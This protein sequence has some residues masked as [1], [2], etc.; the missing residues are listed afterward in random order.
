MNRIRYWWWR[1]QGL[2][3]SLQ[4]KPAAGILASSGWVRSVGG[5]G[6]YLTLFARGGH[7]RAEADQAV[8][9]SEICELPAARGCTH[10]V[11]ASGF[12]LAL[13]AG[14]GFGGECDTTRRL[15]VPGKEIDK[16]C[17][18]VIAAL[19]DGP[20]N[21]EELRLRLRL[22]GLVRN[23]GEEGKK[24]GLTITLPAALGRLQEEGEIRR[25]PVNGR[26]DRQ[27]YRYTLWRPNPLAKCKLSREEVQTEL[28]R[29]YFSWIG[30][31]K[32]SEF[33]WFSGWSGKDAKRAV[34]PLRL[35]PEER[36]SGRVTFAEDAEALRALKAPK[37]PE[38][39][40]V[41]GL[42]GIA[43]LRRDVSGLLDEKDRSREAL[44]GKGV[45]QIGTLSDLPSHAILDR[46]RLI[47]RW[48]F[49]PETSSIAWVNFIPKNRALE[50]AVRA[51]EEFVRDDLG[52]ARSFSLD[53]P[54]SRAPKIA[55]LRAYGV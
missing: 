10:V 49:D 20:L 37:K 4:G 11:P 43:F 23:L 1:R 22:G 17:D 35:V 52:D 27:R 54:N 46:G 28:A 38:Y 12:A 13:K 36:G 51:T 39:A 44:A 6:P 15:G 32:M 14:A 18:G 30:P 19:A 7:R 41:S 5:A 16:L 40:L 29:R 34:E 42:D 9:G 47:G 33:Q 21:P 26:L 53:S 3:G 45:M 2:D 50:A 25:I 24:K 48:E 31:A 8:A 55:A